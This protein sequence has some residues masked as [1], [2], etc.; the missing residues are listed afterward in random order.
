MPRSLKPFYPLGL[1]LLAVFLRLVVLGHFAANDPYFYN[2][3]VGTDNLT[4]ELQA[5]GVLA[6]TWPDSAF[7]YQP[8][9]PF[10]LAGLHLLV[11]PS[12]YNLRLAQA[13]VG[14]LGVL[15]CFWLARQLYGERA[16]WLAGVLYAIYPVFIFYDLSILAA[17]PTVLLGMACLAAFCKLA[18]TK[19]WRWVVATG[20]LIGLGAGMHP[21]MLLVAPVGAL[22]LAWKDWRR[23]LPLAVGLA[24]VSA[25]T[26]APYS[27]WNYRFTHHLSLVSTGGPVIFYV[28]NNRAAAGI[29]EDNLAWQAFRADSRLGRTDYISA[30]WADIRSDPGRWVQL[31]GHKF[32]LAWANAE[33]ANNVSFYEGQAHSPLLAAIPIGFSLVGGLALTGLWYQRRSFASWMLFT[34]AMMLA[35]GM[36]Y[37]VVLSRLRVL[38]LPPL[39]VLAGAALS[40]LLAEWR[41]YKKIVPPLIGAA[42]LMW[43]LDT[44]TGL[45]PR[46]PIVHAV[47]PGYHAVGNVGAATVYIPDSL[48]ALEPGVP[49]WIPVYWQASG[50]F[51]RD[52][53]ALVQVVDGNGQKWAQGDHVA[54]Q[55]GFPYYETSR[56][57]PGDIVSD[58]FLIIPAEDLPAPFTARLWLGLYDPDT[59]ERLPV[60]LAD[61]SPAPD[62]VLKSQPVAMT[63]SGPLA[64]P[65]EARLI[66][67]QVGSATLAAYQTQLNGSTLT[68]TLYWQ[69]GGPMTEDGMVFVHLFDAA[70]KFV[71]GADNRPRNGAYSTQTWQN[72]EGIVDEHRLALPADLP[73]GEYTIEVGMYDS[74]TSNRLPVKTAGGEIAADG[75]LTLE[76]IS[77]LK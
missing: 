28:G 41:Q 65:P 72:G 70:G 60:S 22:W 19:Q 8:A 63:H 27:L 66:N 24:L 4:Y 16:A 76:A 6:G 32:A 3:Q 52:Y 44:A 34:S 73:P 64:L 12:L 38:M 1:Y 56:W 14:A 31:L 39:V 30:A 59:N 35:L 69:S 54:G 26:I 20:L 17:G 9:Y 43:G 21:L 77:I 11:G 45:L 49:Y 7:Y 55:T 48:P 58:R 75:V 33:V 5:R 47:P 18:E 36:S 57:Q 74:A 23:S 67:A 71:L 53:K 61:G 51:D 10:Y 29:N 15:L 42:L 68:L 40:T 13:V 50:T 62:D 37:G 25:A 46:P 2:L